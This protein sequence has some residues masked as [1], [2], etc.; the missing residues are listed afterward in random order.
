MAEWKRVL[1]VVAHPDDAE[2]GSG[3]SIA[4]WIGAGAT[5]AYVI[6]TNGN[7]GAKAVAA[8]ATSSCP[9]PAAHRYRPWR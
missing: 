5:V 2:L 8:V 6:A 7:K 3:G 4:R 1:I 9:C